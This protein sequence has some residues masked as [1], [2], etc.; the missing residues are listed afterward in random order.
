MKPVNIG[1]HSAYQE[2]VLTQLRKYYP[3][4]ATSLSSSTWDILEKFWNLDLSSIDSLMQDRY[5]VFGP[6]PRLPSD[7][8]RSILVS[9]EFKIT[10][11]TRF[12]SDLKEN[13]LHAIISG[14][15]V[16]DTPGVG[17]FY[18]FHRRLWLSDHKNISSAIIHPPKE[19]PKQPKKKGEKADP[20]E[21]VTV[22]TLFQ[23]FQENPP[24][25]MKPCQ[26]LWDIFHTFFLKASVDRNLISLK[27]LA[28]AGDGTPV[29]TAARE[30]KKRTCDCLEKGIRD[31]KCDRIYHQPDCD[32]GWD[33]HNKCFYFGYDL[34]MLTASDSVND[35]PVFPFLGPA[36]RHDS[37]GFL[38]NWFSMKQMLPEADVT[39]LILDSAH[40]AM[41]YYEYCKSN[42]IT[43]FIDL[44]WKCG[45]PP[46][47]KDDITINEDG[48]P[49]C[50]KGFPMKQAAV[51]PKKGRIKYRCLKITCKGGSPKCTC[52]EPC[53]DAKYGRN[54][55]LVLKDNPRLFNNPPRSSDE[56]KLEYN[57][58]TSA[59][60]CNKREKIDYKLEDGRYRSSM[61]WYCRLFSI[62]MCQHLDAWTLPK[63]SLLKDLFD[64]A[65]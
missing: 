22:E 42:G 31:C 49:L 20:V 46:V 55:H 13:H 48:I 11:Y 63:T 33:S 36:S 37:H 30:R 43:P 58:R 51:E 50:P 25:D 15:S 57:A 62:M 60:R 23:Q 41:P 12:S 2:R 40:D 54:V 47:Y 21:K 6:K 35:L 65:A 64:Q 9:V 1:G 18:D 19:K 4:A 14:F 44:N 10:S 28:L 32:T 45:R 8:L 17:T 26:K 3:D 53:S 52:E 39:K 34:Y 16:G 24:S 29:Y 5:S 38:Y 59:E 56:W 7:M 27:N 61:M